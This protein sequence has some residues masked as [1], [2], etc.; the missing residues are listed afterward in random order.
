MITVHD[1]QFEVYLNASSIREEV[2]RVAIQIN[3]DY[4]GKNPLLIIILNGSFIFA[5][6]LVRELSISVEVSFIKLR[7]YE[8]TESTG[9]VK[10][11]IGLYE[12]IKNRDVIIVEDIV[13]SGKTID[14]LLKMIQPKCPR[15]IAVAALLHKPQA[16]RIPVDIRYVGFKIPNKFVL[17]YGLDYQ[18][19]GRNLKDI[20]TLVE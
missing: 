9:N 7:S 8:A 11:L 4:E 1:K 18:G 5:S 19:L 20:F 15:S 3:Q 6:D 17:G 14:H 12:E 13:D 16:T 10:E 2:K